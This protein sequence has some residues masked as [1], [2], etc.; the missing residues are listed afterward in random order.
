MTLKTS[1][2]NSLVSKLKVNAKA[3]VDIQRA[4]I[5]RPKKRNLF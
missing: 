5:F 3:I 1:K 4:T 2:N